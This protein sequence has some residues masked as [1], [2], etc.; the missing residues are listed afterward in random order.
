MCRTMCIVI[1]IAMRITMCIAMVFA[2]QH[3]IAM[4]NCNARD[5]ARMLIYITMHVLAHWHACV[6]IGFFVTTRVFVHTHCNI[7]LRVMKVI[8]RMHLNAFLFIAM[9][10]S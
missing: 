7:L 2:W 6:I 1:R 4:R 9:R 3:C 5:N 8:I 10:A